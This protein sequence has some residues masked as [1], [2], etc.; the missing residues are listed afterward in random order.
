MRSVHNKFI[1]LIIKKFNRSRQYKY[2]KDRYQ[3]Q[4][5]SPYK[6]ININQLSWFFPRVR[7]LIMNNSTTTGSNKPVENNKEPSDPKNQ[8]GLLDDEDLD[9]I[10]E[11]STS[12]VKVCT[13]QR[14]NDLEKGRFFRYGMA[15]AWSQVLW[16]FLSLPELTGI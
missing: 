1:E 9:D 11:K 13:K 2:E 16:W 12:R 14:R 5:S 15:E 10:V 7:W 8:S 3:K 6:I 4:K